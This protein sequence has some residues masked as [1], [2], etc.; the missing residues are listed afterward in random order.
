MYYIIK[1]VITTFLIV[2]IS[3]IS[4]RSSFIGAL[5]ASIP[6]MSVLAML[7]LYV[8]TKDVSKISMLSTSIFWLVLPSLA[9]FVTLPFL[10]KQGINF[11]LS[12]SVSIIVTML[13]Y[14]L[15]VT[16]LNQYGIK[17]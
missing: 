2:L 14:W 7:W 1:I 3:E 16:V 17:L 9:L 15:M 12:L 11:Y 4:K 8:D 5:L 6:L 10:L 13:C